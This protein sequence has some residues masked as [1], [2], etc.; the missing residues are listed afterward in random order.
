MSRF[1]FAL[2]LAT[3]SLAP[4]AVAAPSH[5]F[6]VPSVAE[7]GSAGGQ[8]DG[9]R[10]LAV[11]PANGH[12]YVADFNNA[13][14]S[15]FTR[16]G[17]FVKAWGHGV[18]ASGPGN[19]PRNEIQEVAVD[20][21]G[22]SFALDYALDFGEATGSISHDATATTVRSAFEEHLSIEP[23][24]VAVTGPAG[25]PWAVEFVGRWADVDIP[26]PALE[27]HSLSGG[28]ETATVRTV[29]EG[30]KPEVCV[31]A[32][33][34]VC[35]RGQEGSAAGQLIDPSAVAVDAARDVYVFEGTS[36]RI[37]K[38]DSS[39]EFL[40]AF[41]RDVVAQGPSDS[42]AEERQ[43]LTVA[44]SGG[45]YRLRFPDPF[46]GGRAQETALLPHE[47][48]AAE[49]EAALEALPSIGGIGGSL[50]VSGGPGDESGSS[51]YT[52]EFGG[53][54]AGDDVPSLAGGDNVSGQSPGVSVQTLA[55][56]GGPE[57]CRPDTGDVCKHGAPGTANG[58]F[59]SSAI[60]VEQAAGS[61]FETN[62]AAGPGGTVYVGDR[63]RIQEFEPDGAYKGQLQLPEPGTVGSVAVD[64]T[65]GDVYFD[66]S[67]GLD[68]GVYRLNETTGEVL[69]VLAVAAP[70]ALAVDPAGNV[71]VV[72]DP[73]GVGVG[74]EDE[75]LEFGPTG[76][77]CIVCPADNFA[78]PPPRPVFRKIRLTGLAVQ[79]AC[80]LATDRIYVSSYHFGTVSQVSAFGPNLEDAAKCP[81][82][83]PVTKA[84]GTEPP[85]APLSTQAGPAA[86]PPAAQAKPR[87]CGKG[88]AKAKPKARGKAKASCARRGRSA[89]AQ[90][91]R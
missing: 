20:A 63:N 32:H 74:K 62:L 35:R 78:E 16:T 1:L 6:D 27:A 17:K 85:P 31:V 81:P 48:S 76:G 53:T 75:V 83:G 52:I 22:G 2:L 71:F 64:P 82:G 24:D 70:W 80:D 56:G 60:E 66:Y 59:K 43:R 45:T 91:A 47:A 11:D 4:A 23:G 51:P 15:E 68:P 86:S 40:L 29:Q 77:A 90:R 7:P 39:G 54:L 50:T 61:R 69:D 8:L 38:F 10:G 28:G 79:G 67:G 41:G 49:V 9:P 34:D 73:A 21:T 58:E 42:D 37:S 57:I 26:S 13:R 88:K 44:A 30:A 46:R 36:Q 87:R 84:S 12:L 18:V 19:D 72:D 3:A 65:S 89:R 55:D 14:I 33:G 25:G 5:L